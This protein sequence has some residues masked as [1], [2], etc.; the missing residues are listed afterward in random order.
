M[1]EKSTGSGQNA[2]PS[3]VRMAGVFNAAT[4]ALRDAVQGGNLASTGRSSGGCRL[5]DKLIKIGARLVSR[6]RYVAFQM[7]EVAVPRALFADILR[8]I[9]GL[10]LPPDP[11]PA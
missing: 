1:I 7:A 4:T 2:R 6:G 3:S 11:A 10:R 9:S 5:K 8:L